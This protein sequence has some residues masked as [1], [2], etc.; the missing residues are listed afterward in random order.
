MNDKK[1][2]HPLYESL[3]QALV[4]Q[5]PALTPGKLFGMPCLKQGKKAVLGAFD[6]GVVFKLE[7]P[8]HAGHGAGGRG[9]L[10]PRRKGAADE[11]VGGA[12]PGT[13]GVLVG[14]FDGRAG[15]VIRLGGPC[16]G[17]VGAVKGHKWGRN[18]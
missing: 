11:G 12:W 9:A 7:G 13:S 18:L 5:D 2:S 14:L 16:T 17:T 8:A 6:G 10:R 1:A 4:D 3:V 15:G